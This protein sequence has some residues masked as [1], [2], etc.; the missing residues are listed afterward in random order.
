M[1]SPI[2]WVVRK[3]GGGG[4]GGQTI[5]SG[6]P[7]RLPAYD[8]VPSPQASPTAEDD[9]PPPPAMTAMPGQPGSGAPEDPPA[10]LFIANLQPLPGGPASRAS[11]RAT[12]LLGT[13][14]LTA[15]VD[16]TFEHLA[17]EEVAAKLAIG[18]TGEKGTVVLSL[19][20]GQVTHKFWD[21]KP[22]GNL[23]RASLMTAFL[24]IRQ[25]LAVRDRHRRPRPRAKLGGAFLPEGQYGSG[26]GGSGSGCSSSGSGSASGTSQGG[27]K[28]RRGR[29]YAGSEAAHH[30]TRWWEKLFR[31]RFH[32]P[33]DG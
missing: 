22:S 27:G 21:L 9:S 13:G 23:S 28:A 30:R 31:A 7:C 5:V 20:P 14:Y 25:P 19:S 29:P 10:H 18:G 15:R 8:T 26:G 3:G 33:G 17:S 6:R 12:I 32:P 24:K 16:V 2:K 11:G 1:R 4:G